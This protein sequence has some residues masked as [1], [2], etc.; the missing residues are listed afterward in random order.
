[1]IMSPEEGL[2]AWEDMPNDHSGAKWVDNML[3]IGV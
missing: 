3:I 2:W 1:M